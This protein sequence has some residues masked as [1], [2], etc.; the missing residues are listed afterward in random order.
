MF[1]LSITRNEY[2]KIIN[3]PGIYVLSSD[4]GVVLYVGRSLNLKNRVKSHLNSTG[5]QFISMHTGKFYLIDIIYHDDISS[6]DDKETEI[7]LKLKPQLNGSKTNYQKTIDL[8]SINEYGKMPII[9]CKHKTSLFNE[10]GSHANFNGFCTF[11]NPDNFNFSWVLKGK[12]I[13]T[14]MQRLL[15]ENEFKKYPMCF[16]MNKQT[17][18]K[19]LLEKTFAEIEYINNEVVLK[20][21]KHFIIIDEDETIRLEIR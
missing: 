10:C 12:F 14:E 7:I 8:S 11:H 5:N 21:K 18:G 16:Y 13:T 4:E 3:K 2:S 9:K 1:D 19:L 17:F 15:Y 6:L 20:F